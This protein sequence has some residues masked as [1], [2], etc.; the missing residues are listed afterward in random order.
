[1][2]DKKQDAPDTLPADF[3]HKAQPDTLPG[4]FSFPTGPGGRDTLP[5]VT[6]QQIKHAGVEALKWLPAVGATV[7]A[8]AQPELFP[9][10]AGFLPTTAAASGA[11]A[12][13]GGLGRVAELG[14][15]AAAGEPVPHGIGALAK[16]VGGEAL[17][18]GLM[19]AGG[20]LAF[21]PL[22]RGA[23]AIGRKIQ[24]ST[25][26]PRMVDMRDGFDWAVLD[27]FKLKGNLEQ[28]L[29]QV[30][31]ELDRLRTARNNLIQ[32]GTSTVDLQKVFADTQSELARDLGN[33][34]YAGQGQKTLAALKSIE[35]D[36]TKFAGN[37]PVDVRVAENAKEHFGKMGAWSYGR[38]DLD[39]AVQEQVADRLYL[40]LKDAIEQ[41]LGPQG[42]EVKSLN[43]Q[44]QKLLPVKHAM[45]AR[46]P[47]EERNRMFSLADIA[48][49]TP[50]VITGDVTKL[51]L[52]GL[53]RAQK[54]LRVGNFLN[55][56]PQLPGAR[57]A[58][59]IAARALDALNPNNQ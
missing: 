11:A 31:S 16:D 52:A 17:K 49:M 45:M 21:E 2:A 33:L 43:K 36:V 34:K 15:R 48:A 10:A 27:R 54:S 1:M 22:A 7:A 20:R 25:I 44:M 30:N 41:S 55:R 40:K 58:V 6:N 24:A 12:I 18:Q 32:P 29:G 3:F 59:P 37:T 53:T 4:N 13:G 23:S 50:A 46:I 47:V 28:S 8:I 51:G 38:T 42:D 5:N 39:S 56:A 26:R 19:E 14:G 9:V 35:D 57:E